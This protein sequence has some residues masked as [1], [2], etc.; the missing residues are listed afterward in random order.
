MQK[1]SELEGYLRDCEE[2][3]KEVSV[4]ATLNSRISFRPGDD[5]MESE[6]VDIVM[7]ESS[8]YT[9]QV[10]VLHVNENFIRSI[11]SCGK[12]IQISRMFF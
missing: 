2:T 8:A 11:G 3:K 6:H 4:G 5:R 1:E 10:P 7:E 9:A 12:S